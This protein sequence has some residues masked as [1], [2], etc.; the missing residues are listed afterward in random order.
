MLTKPPWV[1]ADESFW[2]R[3]KCRK[4]RPWTAEENRLV[5]AQEE[6]NDDILAEKIKRTVY[7]VR[8]QRERLKTKGERSPHMAAWEAKIMMADSNTEHNSSKSASGGVARRRVHRQP[9]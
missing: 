3:R 1:L 6:D 8:K 4:R 2:D 9:R 7:A 5:L